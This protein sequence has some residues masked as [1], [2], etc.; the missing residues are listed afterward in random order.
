MPRLVKRLLILIIS[1]AWIPI[2]GEAYLRLFHPVNILPRYIQAGE[3]GIRENVPGSRYRH[4]T[5]EYSVAFDITDQGI[6]D[7]RIFA[8]HPPDGT[9]RV[10]VIGDSFGMGYGVDY[11]D[12]VPALLESSL[13]S[14]LG[15]PVEVVNLSVSGI[16]TAEQLVTL[17]HR[18]WDLQPDFVVVYWQFSDLADNVR[19]QLYRLNS[20]ELVRSARSYL[21]AVRLREAL[22]HYSAYRWLA[23][24]SHFYSW[25]RN[26]A[27]FYA[28]SLLASWR[29]MRDAPP[30]S[31]PQSKSAGYPERLAASLLGRIREQC[32]QHGAEFIVCS[33]PNRKGR[34][35]F[36]DVFPEA[37]AISLGLEF[38]PVSPIPCFEADPKSLYYWEHSAGHWT[39]SGTDCV[40]QALSARI[41][42]ILAMPEGAAGQ[43]V[44]GKE[45]SPP[46]AAGS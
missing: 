2:A 21:P 44:L 38:Q 42:G 20:G 40:A 16:G 19:S 17:D 9:L 28:R 10:L 3:H 27:G 39:P 25:I 46:S 4:S 8:S 24:H 23:Q 15:S 43:S 30:S 18:G 26:N 41:Q 35:K 13:S 37:A 5:T 14:S 29:S 36:I 22:F 12:S 31:G 6:R 32:V 11:A 34:G 33:I 45:P 1:I 7:S